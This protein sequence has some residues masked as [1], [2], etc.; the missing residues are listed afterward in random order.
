MTDQLNPAP[1]VVEHD[2]AAKLPAHGGSNVTNE[3]REQFKHHLEHYCH[4]LS[5][6]G[7]MSITFVH[8][9]SSNPADF[10]VDKL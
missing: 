6:Q 7:P 3:M 2:G 1:A 9:S 10:Y 4:M 8:I 5:E